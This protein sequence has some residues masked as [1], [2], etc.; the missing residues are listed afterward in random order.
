MKKRKTT[1]FS[2]LIIFISLS[3]IFIPGC[4][5]GEKTEEQKVIKIG[6]ILPLTGNLSFIG[7]LNKNGIDLAVKDINEKSSEEE[8]QIQVI[9]E[10]SKSSSTDGVSA[11]NKLINIHNINVIIVST[12][13]IAAACA[14]IAEKSEVIE[15]AMSP[16]PEIANLGSNIFRIFPSSGQEAEILA[17]H[18]ANKGINNVAILYSQDD[19]GT[20]CKISFENFFKQLGGKVIQED[21]Y[22]EGQQDVKSQILNIKQT[23]PEAIVMFG[24]GRTYPSILKNLKEQS[25]DIGIYGNLAFNNAPIKQIA[26]KERENIVFTVPSFNLNKLQNEKVTE[27]IR[28]YKEN[29]K[30][31]PDHSSAY[32]YDTVILLFEAIKRANNKTASIKNELFRVKDF[33]G[34]TGNISIDANGDSRTSIDLA[35]YQNGI[36]VP[37]NK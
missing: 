29:Y 15:I 11:M 28:E 24:F 17:K 30:S 14:P 35:Y 37:I 25:I 33:R 27:Y 16:Q 6:A 18:I 9:Y 21:S 19:Y 10:D 26:P 4:S 20:A 1:I 22:I 7:K 5:K 31:E 23:S 8:K 32:F 36:A 34:I 12:T 13:N 3:I 2:T